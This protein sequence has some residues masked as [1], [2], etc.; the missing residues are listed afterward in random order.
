MQTLKLKSDYVSYPGLIDAST[1]SSVFVSMSSSAATSA[2]RNYD[3]KT[4]IVARVVPT[5]RRVISVN[6]LNITN[7][8]TSGTTTVRSVEKGSMILNDKTARLVPAQM[9]VYTVANS[10]NVPKGK[11][12]VSSP[13]P[14][15]Q[16]TTSRFYPV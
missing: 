8:N 14:G 12:F 5:M 4:K 10:I 7:Y 9:P 11:T 16:P 13:A 1:P 15:W 6:S 2:I 3:S